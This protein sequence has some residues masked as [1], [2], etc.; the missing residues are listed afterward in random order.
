[1]FENKAVWITGASSGIG[2]ALAEAFAQRGARLILSGRRVEALE[3]VQ[4]LCGGHNQCRI[5]PFE[6]TDFDALPGLVDE[7]W[8]FFDGV[9]ILVNNAGISQRSAAEDT[10]FSVYREV[11][12]IDLMA[13]IALTQLILPKMIERQS[14][15]IVGTSS[16]AGLI[17][18][19]MR[20]AYSAAKH[21]LVGYL[22]ALRVETR[23]HGISVHV[24]APGSVKTNVARNALSASGDVRGKSDPVI[25]NGM[26]PEKAASIV[27]AGIEKG[28][29]EIIIAEGIERQIVRLRRFFPEL[30][31]RKLAETYEKGYAAKLDDI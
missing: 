12:E 3:E 8:G 9:D 5:L 14:G 6:T 20:T 24:V 29:G 7:A 31:F 15:R 11:V 10:V 25:E 13:P 30:A 2:R 17:G 23:A 4:A 18:A 1:M 27:L 19:P 21:G 16:V 22:D 28:K 26:L